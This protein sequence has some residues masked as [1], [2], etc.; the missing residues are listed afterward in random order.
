MKSPLWVSVFLLGAS[1]CC[2]SGWP[3]ESAR[4]SSGDAGALESSLVTAAVASSDTAP[5]TSVETT[6]PGP[7]RSFQR[8]AGIS[9]KASPEEVLPLLA[10]EMNVRGYAV[11]RPTEYLILLRRYVEQARELV[12]LAG[13]E[14][15]IHV[16]SCAEAGPLLAVLGY[17]L[18]QACGPETTLQVADSAKAFL[19][20]DS[21]F[22]LAAFEESLRAGKPF[23]L[24]YPSSRVPVLFALSDWA[25]SAGG[26][27]AGSLKSDLVD[28]L[29]HSS[30]LARL[31]SALAGMDS[32][33][34]LA[35][36]QSLGVAKLVHIAKVLDFYGS[37]ICIRSGKVLVPGGTSAEKAWKDL[38]GADPN[39]PGQFVVRLASEDAGWL[40]SY[41]DAL[42]HAAPA[43]QAYF[44]EPRRLRRFYAALRG[45]DVAP[46]PAR[47]ILRSDPG[48]WLLIARLQLEAGQPSVPGDLEVWKDIVRRNRDT[49]RDREWA[50]R[51]ENWQD[52][53]QLLEGM[54]ALSRD[55]KRGQP[56]EI[57]LTLSAIDR[58]RAPQKR[59]TPATVTLLA[60]RFWRLG[61]QY[62]VFSEFPDLSNES[63]AA[64]LKAADALDGIA[65]PVLRANT[66]GIFQ[67]NLGLWQILVRQGQISSAN[68]NESWQ[69]VI[70]P[71]ADVHA[72]ARLFDAGRASLE[73]LLA[74]GA[75]RSDLSQDEIIALLAGPNLVS[76]EAQQAKDQLAKK[77]RSVMDAQRL[78]SLDT[79]FA[80]GTGLDQLAQG[81]TTP[82]SLVPLAAQL[83]E[84]EL[85]RPIFSRTLQDVQSGREFSDVRHTTLQTRT[86]LQK[87]IRSGSTKERAEARGRL[88]PF[89]RDTLV[90][91]NYTYYD[92][93]GAQMLYNNAVFV[94]SHDYSEGMGTGAEQPWITP[95]LV[96]LSNSSGGGHLAGSL[97]GLPYALAE[98]EQN[99]IV[100]ENVQSLIWED[101]VP[102]LLTSAVLPRFW[103][104]TQPELHAVALY[105]RTGEELLGRAAEDEK[106]RGIVM[107]ILSDRVPPQKLGRVEAALLGGRR[108]EA[109]SQVLPGETFYLAA[110]FRRRFPEEGG[111]WETAGREL[112]SLARRYPADVNW[113]RLSQDFGVPH[114]ALAHTYGRELLSVKPFPAFQSYSSRLM[115]ECWDSNNLYWA[116]L[117]DELGYQPVMLNRLVPELTH[118]MVEKLFATNL[119]DWTAVSRAMRET[120]EEFRQGKIVPL[121]KGGAV[122]LQ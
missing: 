93:P 18:R 80:L 64:F 61:D 2:L 27:N 54:F 22:P 10:H 31:Y 48:F 21:G 58:R 20:G 69:R 44:T 38:V 77:M 23:V 25:T 36:R 90:G 122:S 41:F 49:R 57:Y 16:S 108:E 121:P 100:P 81:T 83:R 103:G 94:R 63:I 47:A 85:P 17:Q 35:L 32:E 60:D 13:P 12:A 88:A 89:L 46:G 45:K 3:R 24:P 105:Q 42:A 71:F 78:V 70:S 87:I 111:N 109:L 117:A 75:G 113:E 86:D 11:G 9:Q 52:P 59:L 119:E 40:A 55:F 6:I 19:A 65:S 8:M 120:G 118:R 72:A 1:C 74:A 66:I 43:Q 96:N 7:L 29:L 56:L 26:A 91:L 115:A 82:D 14:A 39:S 62:S 37:Q 51:S 101:F 67:S 4:P 97:S 53:E 28:I 99:F 104:V 110:E 114:P 107:E 84:F 34:V 50:S 33:T 95:R 68:L 98:V 92:P 79:L 116:R 30:S 5:S 106:L 76:P 112:D 73:A 15:V 102:S